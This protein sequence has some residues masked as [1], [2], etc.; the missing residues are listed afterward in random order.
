MTHECMH[1][2][3][4]TDTAVAISVYSVYTGYFKCFH[5]A[6]EDGAYTLSKL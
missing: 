6:H 4:R 5:L 3:Y 1:R 2:V